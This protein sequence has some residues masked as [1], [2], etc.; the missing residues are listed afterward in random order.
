MN[1]LYYSFGVMELLHR[2]KWRKGLLRFLNGRVRKKTRILLDRWTW[3]KIEFNYY[4]LN[5]RKSKHLILIITSIGIREFN[6]LKRM[7]IKPFY[8][9]NSM[10]YISR[11]YI[12]TYLW[13]ILERTISIRNFDSTIRVEFSNQRNESEK[14]IRKRSTKADINRIKKNWIRTIEVTKIKSWIS[15]N[16]ISFL[17]NS[18]LEEAK[19]YSQQLIKINCEKFGII[20]TL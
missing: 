19:R 12:Y 14:E 8:L 2:V 20:R 17:A 13:Y 18:R 1:C 11:W 5:R 7:Q 3:C 6:K 16:Y 4:R 15:H 9:G 10:I